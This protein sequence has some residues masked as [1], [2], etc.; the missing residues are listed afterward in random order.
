MTEQTC[1]ETA[2]KHLRQACL[3]IAVILI[4]YGIVRLSEFLLDLVKIYVSH[5]LWIAFQIIA[6]I[7]IVFI[8]LRVYSIAKT[9][10]AARFSLLWR[11]FR[12]PLLVLLLGC[13]ALVSV[14][15]YPSS[16]LDSIFPQPFRPFSLH[17]PISFSYK[18][19]FRWNFEGGGSIQMYTTLIYP[20][21]PYKILADVIYV[22]NSW[23][24][25][26]YEIDGSG[27]MF[28]ALGPATAEIKVGTIE[29]G[30]Y[31]FI[32]VMS[33]ATD[34][35]QIRKTDNMFWIEEVNALMGFVVQKNEFEK[36]LDG[37]NVAFIGF[38]NIEEE[39]IDFVLESIQQI[40][41]AIIENESYYEGW[42]VHVYFYYSG[43]LSNL[44]QIILEVAEEHPEY[45]VGVYSNIGWH[46]LTWTYTFS[47]GSKPQYSDSIKEVILQ[48]CLRIYSQGTW[49]NYIVFYVSS[50]NL[51]KTDLEIKQDL[52]KSISETLGLKEINDFYVTN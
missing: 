32:V 25:I 24:V 39:T 16:A 6:A 27:A 46:E 37:F 35:F 47:V 33:N 21:M 43:N 7:L 50:A 19:N 5:Y 11:E 18:L 13:L 42:T 49:G 38:P 26:P 48:K 22:S 31:T 40:G 17:D 45:M 9:I 51:G 4:L 2:M 36:R 3:A 34:L 15:W 41:G 1:Q 8:G 44:R 12:T 10:K 28:C 23:I 14:T 29:N 52:V 20:S 30:N